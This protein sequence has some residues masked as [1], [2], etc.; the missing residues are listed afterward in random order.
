MPKEPV[1]ISH[2]DD[3]L[4]DEDAS[5]PKN[6]SWL[7]KPQRKLGQAGLS[8][9][10]ILTCTIVPFSFDMYT[11]AV[12]SLP[13][14]FDTTEQ[15]VN[16][17]LM[18][19]LLVMTVASLLFGP[20]SDRIGRKPV[21][22]GSLVVYT[23]GSIMCFL[24]PNIGLLVAARLVQALG[25]GALIAVSM[26]LVKDCFAEERR[27]QMIAII[28]VLSVLGPVIAPLI[29]G[30]LLSFFNWRA[31]FVA[32]AILGLC[33][34]VFAV[35]FDESLPVS[36]RSTGG[37]GSTLSGLIKVGRNLTFTTLLVMI[38][39][40]SVAFNAYLAV[41]SYIYVDYFGTTPQGYTYFFAVTAAFTALGPIIWLKA[42]KK[43]TPRA[44]THVMIALGIVSALA[45]L[46]FGTFSVFAFCG[47][48]I[49]FATIQSAIRPYT[50]N[51]LL[52][53]QQSDTGAASSLINFA[54]SIFGVIG[55]NVIMFDWPNY[56]FGIGAIMLVGSCLSLALWVLLLRSP[57]LHVKEFDK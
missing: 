28:Q 46:A 13:S 47:A 20:V 17:T 41:A 11:P 52:S 54:I 33:C 9:F 53:L 22:V 42:S 26:A 36:E 30:F 15:M 25:A 48:F 3:R 16:L 57:N 4:A 6:A 18:G 10:I 35:L 50:T 38:A 39:L 55:M 19:F 34:L 7:I 12:P 8:F 21:L 23:V 32:L 31:S 56:I 2:R 37:V 43:V 44:F 51:V 40:Y 1:E 27:E 45:L 29:G 14:Y 24:A 5:T 49:L